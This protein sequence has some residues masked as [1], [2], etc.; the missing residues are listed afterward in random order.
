MTHK[1]D[2]ADRLAAAKAKHEAQNPVVPPIASDEMNQGMR[3]F[4]EMLG[5][6]LGSGLMGWCLDAYFG[7]GPRMLLI[8]IFLGIIAAFYNVYKLSRNMGTAI[9]SKSLQNG[10]KAANKPSQNESK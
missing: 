10:D 2:F 7:T 3:A 4:M 5:V 1:D 8:F 6:L 9:G